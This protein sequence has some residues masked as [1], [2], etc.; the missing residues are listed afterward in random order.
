[1][2]WGFVLSLAVPGSLARKVMFNLAL[3]TPAQMGLPPYRALELPGANGIGQVRDL[4]RLYGEFATGA[5]T[6]NLRP[7]VLADLAR[8]ATPPRHGLRDKVLK[9]TMVYSL[10]LSKP[11]AGF[12]FSPSAN[13]FG[14]AG[15]GG[16]NAFAD[17]DAQLG[18]AYAPNRLGLHQF[19][20][21]REQALRKA[22]YRCIAAG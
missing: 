6:L 13:A 21:P 20:D 12:P 14:A 17:P 19:D 11:F 8:P 15:T 4:A 9:R 22:M 7:A 3:R 1:M 10:G 2:P 16:S 5:R 18:F